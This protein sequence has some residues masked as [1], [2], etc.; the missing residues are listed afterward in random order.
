LDNI[1][2]STGT[3][4]ARIVARLKRDAPDIAARLAAGE[5]RSARAAGIEAGIV[6]PESL[7][8]TIRRAWK[9]M[10]PAADWFDALSGGCYLAAFR[11]FRSGQ[12]R[13][14]RAADLT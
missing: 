5:F 7:L 6:K 9:R 8:T 10:T 4:A 2:V 11:L 13:L 3:S 12:A 1:Q 14:C